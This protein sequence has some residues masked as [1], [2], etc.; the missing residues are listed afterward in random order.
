VVLWRWGY[1]VKHVTTPT[2]LPREIAKSNKSICFW[3]LGSIPLPAFQHKLLA[4]Y[5]V[6][7]STTAAGCQAKI[8]DVW[9]TAARDLQS[10]HYQVG[11]NGARQPQ[12][13]IMVLLSSS[14]RGCN[15]AGILANVQ[16]WSLKPFA[17][18]RT[19]QYRGADQII[20]VP[21]PGTSPSHPTLPTHPGPTSLVIDYLR[22]FDHESALCTG[23]DSPCWQIFLILLLI[24]AMLVLSF[25]SQAA[26][27]GVW[28][29]GHILSLVESLYSN[30]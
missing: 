28:P 15:L 10:R 4:I 17:S 27:L 12:S 22:V 23:L 14:F 25:P 5:L 11:S 3:W 21:L 7:S 18:Y 19:D 2:F 20:L 1:L 30:T 8:S 16:D 29:V 6:V 24:S 13:S 9:R 26:L